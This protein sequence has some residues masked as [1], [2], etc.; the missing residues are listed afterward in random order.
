MIQALFV[1]TSGVYFDLLG[2]DNCWDQTRDARN[3]KGTEPVVCHSPCNR[4]VNFAALNYKRY[5]YPEHL[6]PGNDDG[7][8]AHALWCVRTFGGVL[9]HPASSNAWKA[10]E[11]K[12]PVKGKGWGWGQPSLFGDGLTEYTCHVAQSAYGHHA[13]KDTWLLF[14]GKQPP[15]DLNWDRPAGTAQ[16]GWFDNKRA[17]GTVKK[18]LGKKE[19]SRTPVAF[20]K[21]L[22][23]LAEWSRG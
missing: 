2:P 11:L 19:A 8:F 15:F 9:E 4:W 5:G 1:E 13:R 22:I 14:C 23:R 12:R 3:Y 10:Y 17:D 21:E 7:C 20:A 16:C 6:R 18:T